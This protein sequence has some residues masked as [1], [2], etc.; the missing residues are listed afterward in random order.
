MPYIKKKD[1]KPET[2][3][4]KEKFVLDKNGKYKPEEEKPEE[5]AKNLTSLGV[6]TFELEKGIPIATGRGDNYFVEQTKEKVRAILK[7]MKNGDSFVIPQNN[8]VTIKRLFEEEFPKNVFKTVAL[9][10][11]KKFRR[12]WKIS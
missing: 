10:P 11:E 7:Q 3:V 12:I 6:P 2:P 1:G 5:K 4:R 8:W 9:Q